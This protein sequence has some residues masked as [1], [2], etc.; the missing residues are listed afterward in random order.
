[1]FIS[2]LTVEVW[3]C[4]ICHVKRYFIRWIVHFLSDLC[5][6]ENGDYNFGTHLNVKKK[7]FLFQVLQ[8]LLLGVVIGKRQSNCRGYDLHF[9]KYTSL[10]KYQLILCSKCGKQLVYKTGCSVKSPFS[11]Y[12]FVCHL[13]KHSKR[14]WFFFTI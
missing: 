4:V 6:V 2:R 5:R 13:Q 12:Y 9:T 7:I 1:L 14:V 3:A 11:A 8:C 10:L